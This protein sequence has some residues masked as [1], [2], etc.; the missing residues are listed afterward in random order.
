MTDQLDYAPAL[1]RTDL[2]APPVVEALRGGDASGVRVAP[3]DPSA[4]DTAEFCA[5]Y[6]VGLDESANCVVVVGRREG[7]ERYAAC[8]VLA[9]TRADVNGAGRRLL[10]VRKAS[11]AP[12]ETAV[13]LTGM[14]HGGITPVGLPAD[15]LV[16]VD[17]AVASSASVIVGSGTRTAKL[18]LSGAD[19]V[20]LSG[21]QVVDGLGRPVA[22]AGGGG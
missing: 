20:A 15:W 8:V 19:L 4:A 3:V 11:F 5:R 16:L 17:A 1:D 12:M 9:T 7:I 6:G 13:G 21:G 14:E 22:S 10:G 18:R 2:L